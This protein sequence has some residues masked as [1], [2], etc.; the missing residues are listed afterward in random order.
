VAAAA[1]G[2]YGLGG[3]ASTLAFGSTAASA[4]AFLI[5]AAP[6]YGGLLWR[7]RRVLHLKEILER[8]LARGEALLRSLK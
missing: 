4:V 2:C 7:L 5:I 8:L 6:V 1:V 3:I